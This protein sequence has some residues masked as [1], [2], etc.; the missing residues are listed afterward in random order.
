MSIYCLSPP[1]IMLKYNQKV[2]V[3]PASMTLLETSRPTLGPSM[4][5]ACIIDNISHSPR[6]RKKQPMSKCVLFIWGFSYWLNDSFGSEIVCVHHSLLQVYENKVCRTICT[7]NE[8]NSVKGSRAYET[9][10]SLFIS[11][12]FQNHSTMKQLSF[13]STFSHIS[14]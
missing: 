2:Q 5:T 7:T 13:C 6:R 8:G 14:T 11:F 12:C 3:K 1:P 9:V 4:N 10:F